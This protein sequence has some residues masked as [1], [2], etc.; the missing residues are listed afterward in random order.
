M[1]I[2]TLDNKYVNLLLGLIIAL[3]VYFTLIGFDIDKAAAI[4]AAI[5]AL[6]VT[7]WVTE[8]LPIPVTSIV[9]FVLLPLFG[10][11][12][13]K[14]VSSALGSHVILLLMGAFMLSKAL[15]KSNVHERLAIYMIRLVGLSSGKRLVFAFM[16]ASASLSMWISN[17]ATTL[18]MLPIAL[19]I[20]AKVNNRALSCAL[21]LGIAYSASLGGVATPIGTPPNVIFMGIYEES[22]G[23]EMG[24]LAWMKIGVPVVLISLPLMALWLTRNINTSLDIAL[25]QLSSWGSDEKRVLIIFG[26]TALAWITRQEPFGGWTGLLGLKGVGDSTIAL[27]AV[28][29]MF[30]TPDGKKGR[31]LDWNTAVTIP[32]GMLLL[33]AGGIAIAKGF[34]ASGLSH[35]I[36]DWLASMATISILS[37]IFIICLLVT[38]LT[39]ITSNTATATLLLPILAAAALTSGQDPLLFMVPATICAS[40]AF[41]L[42]VATAPNAIAYGTGEVEI[43][44]MVREG[45][46]LS[47]LTVFTTTGVT[48]LMLG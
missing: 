6:T 18:I 23:K 12:D 10:V 35:L 2:K 30:M 7:W 44:E 40:C 39:E 16:L 17:T 26:L 45:F 4:T 19:A 33:F 13:H 27:A 21:I 22:I 31:L 48:Y 29:L 9:P 34:V 1:N 15:E 25:P 32:W 28:V 43:K 8:S 11:L 5:T 20:L 47:L 46:I 37:M 38:Y 14:S 42:P 24:F 41:M 36:G 3:G